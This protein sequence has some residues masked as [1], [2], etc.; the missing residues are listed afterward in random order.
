[1]TCPSHVRATGVNSRHVPLK[2]GGF[3]GGSHTVAG[4]WSVLR[5]QRS[6]VRIL[7]GAPAFKRDLSELPSALPSFVH[8]PFRARD[9]RRMV[10]TRSGSMRSTGSPVGNADAP[11]TNQDSTQ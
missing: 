7:L 3:A 6:E 5:R 2:T 4:P 10:E 1:M 9:E 8:A 11:M